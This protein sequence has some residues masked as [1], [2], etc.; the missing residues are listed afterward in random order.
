MFKKSLLK[1]KLKPKKV[2]FILESLGNSRV[3]LVI[4][5]GFLKFLIILRKKNK[6]AL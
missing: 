6:E 5:V 2:V 1:G 3:L 4:N